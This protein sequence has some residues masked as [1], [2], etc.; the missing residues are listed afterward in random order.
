[1]K[2]V[3]YQLVLRPKI[4]FNEGNPQKNKEIRD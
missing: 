4:T 1:M 3:Y 2:N